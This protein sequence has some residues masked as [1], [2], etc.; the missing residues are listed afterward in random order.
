MDVL[1]VH[2]MC[3]YNSGCHDEMG[4]SE[5]N[6]YIHVMI[7]LKRMEL[8]LQELNEVY[9][10][11]NV[12]LD[13]KDSHYIKVDVVTNLI[14]KISDEIGRKAMDEVNEEINELKLTGKL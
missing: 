9:Y 14:D 6:T 3:T 10:S 12:L 7:K 13:Q 5:I 1:R 11:L 2:I 4:W 8:T